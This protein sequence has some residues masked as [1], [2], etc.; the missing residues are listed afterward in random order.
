MN[1]KLLGIMLAAVMAV[2]LGGCGSKSASSSADVTEE[3]VAAGKETP[4]AEKQAVSGEQG[5]FDQS[6]VINDNK[7][8][9]VEFWIWDAQDMFQELVDQYQA[10]R[11]NV[12]IKL[13]N[14]PWDDYWTK[15]PLSLR[16]ENGPAVFAV[17][18]SQHENLINYMAP[19]DIPL[20]LLQNDFV[21]VDAHVI[22][23]KVYYI[24]YG[25]MTGTIYYNK[26]L[27]TE[28]GLTDGD[29]P[30][31]WDE[32]R[33]VAKKLTKQ[34][35]SGN[36]TQAGFNFNGGYQ[37]IIMGLDYQNGELLFKEDGTTPNID[38]EAMVK[39]T[40]FLFDLYNKDKVGSKDFGVDAG[41][42]FGQG[43]TAMVYK[44]GWYNNYLIDKYPNI[45]YGVFE[46][47]IPSE[48]EPFA[49]DR[50][51][52]ESTMGINKNTSKEQ[53]VV[54]Q[55]FVKFFLSSDDAMKQF[56]LKYSIFPTKKA[57]SS[58]EEIVNHPVLKVLAPHI[59]RYIW[60]G[61][62]PNNFE[63]LLK[64]IYQEGMYNNEDIQKLLS[65]AQVKL[66]D[67]LSESDFVSAE[68]QYK[69]YK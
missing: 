15:L 26:D 6:A 31:T 14:Q 12:K 23:D 24:D 11:P 61:P 28:A 47:P 55:D 18:N 66:E 21:G 32:F 49:Y 39:N 35:P 34:D 27:W 38:N 58:A 68:K 8:I 20:S 53:Q 22:D 67:E 59:E 33:A 13:V 17:H 57:L 52:G 44:W 37:D 69:F 7:P 65:A 46:I 41:E 36:M 42:S 3:A 4:A 60:P 50:Y 25:M 19:Y 51:N 10:V 62:I 43:K 40:Q 1:K 54:A 16:G 29:I 48:D 30:K 56:C 5:V 63:D 9:E 45:K 64:I 2:S